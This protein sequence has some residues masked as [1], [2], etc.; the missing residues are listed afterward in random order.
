MQGDRADRAQTGADEPRSMN[1]NAITASAMVI[2][3]APSQSVLRL[4][5]LRFRDVSDVMSARRNEAA[6]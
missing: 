2:V 1:T 4:F 5:V 3:D 6:R